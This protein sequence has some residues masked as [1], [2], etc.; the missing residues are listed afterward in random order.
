MLDYAQMKQE[1]NNEMDEDGIKQSESESKVALTTL[2]WSTTSNN[3]LLKLELHLRRNAIEV[4]RIRQPS[5]PIMLRRK[6][7]PS[8][9]LPRL[10]KERKKPQR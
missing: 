9:V 4:Q 10:V 8:K 5:L 6:C 2:L 7:Q 3:S 1:Y